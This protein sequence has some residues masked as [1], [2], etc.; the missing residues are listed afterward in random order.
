LKKGKYDSILLAF[1]Y[2]KTN[3]SVYQY[4]A[5]NDPRGAEQIINSF[6]YE[7]TDRR[8]LGQSLSELVSQ[9]GEPALVKVMEYHP[10]KDIILELNSKDEKAECS[11]GKCKSSRN[12]EHYFNASG[13]EAPKEA[14]TETMAHQ[15]NI[16]LVVATLFIVTALIY[17][18]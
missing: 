11:C 15:T 2:K 16:V 9:V 6:G 12:Q 7:V 10:D 14:K 3:M 4:V 13:S 18:K 17:K 5:D 1:F 8:N